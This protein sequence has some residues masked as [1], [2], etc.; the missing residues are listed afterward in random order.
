[1]ENPLIARLWYEVAAE[2][3]SVAPRVK[4]IHYEDL[5]DSSR[6]ASQLRDI[7]EFLGLPVNKKRLQCVQEAE[8]FNIDMFS[9]RNRP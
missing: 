3:L 7:L 2:W 5:R 9:Y 4:V 8:V 6:V 1:M